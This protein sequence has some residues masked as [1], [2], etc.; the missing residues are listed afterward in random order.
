MPTHTHIFIVVVNC[1]ELSLVN[2]HVTYTELWLRNGALVR[3]LDSVASF[4]CDHGY[5][6]TGSNSATCQQS[7]MWDQEIST[8]TQGNEL[9]LQECSIYSSS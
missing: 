9:K 8:C 3:P 2:G 6:L 7:S 4:T 5:R 1:P